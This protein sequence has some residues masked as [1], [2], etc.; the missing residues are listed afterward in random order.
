M[1]IIMT[2]EEIVAAFNGSSKVC[3]AV[4]SYYGVNSG[5]IEQVSVEGGVLLSHMTKACLDIIINLEKY[6]KTHQ[7][8]F[9]TPHVA[10]IG[11][12]RDMTNSSATDA[13]VRY[14]KWRERD[15]MGNV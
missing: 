10:C 5:D 7:T 14:D 6:N 12:I 4:L 3:D 8:S 2:T 15:Y 9:M 11:T 1:K 13:K